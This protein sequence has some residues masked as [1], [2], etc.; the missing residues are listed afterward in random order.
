MFKTK[1]ETLKNEFDSILNE[2]K[3]I[4]VAAYSDVNDFII[5]TN[6]VLSKIDKFDLVFF[7]TENDVN[8]L[9]NHV[10]AL[11]ILKDE[12]QNAINNLINYLNKKIE[13]Y[14]NELEDYDTLNSDDEK[15]RKIINGIKIL[16]K[17]ESVF[18]PHLNLSNEIG[19]SLKQVYDSSDSIQQF[20]KDFDNR[21]YPVD[22]WFLGVP[23]V[24]ENAW[25]FENIKSLS[26]GLNPTI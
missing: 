23:R 10:N 6:A 5:K 12:I 16:L 13:T 7:D 1:V 21:E 18:L 26:Q 17:E 11:H 19:D 25:N 8:N 22:D 20:A 3:G 9:S 24:R 14:E 15:I 2:L 4:D